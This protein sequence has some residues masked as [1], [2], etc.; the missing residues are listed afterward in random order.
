MLTLNKQ[1][2]EVKQRK[3]PIPAKKEKIQAILSLPVLCIY[4][5]TFTSSGPRLQLATCTDNKI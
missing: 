4:P 2:V 1:A 5:V 3:N